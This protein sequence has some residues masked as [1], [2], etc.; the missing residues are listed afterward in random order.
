VVLCGVSGV[1]DTLMRN[2]LIEL[3]AWVVSANLVHRDIIVIEVKGDDGDGEFSRPI[4]V[5]TAVEKMSLEFNLT[6]KFNTNDVR[7]FCKEFRIKVG[8]RWVSVADP[9]PKVQSLCA[10]VH[11]GRGDLDLDERWVSFVA[12]LRHYDN[13]LVLDTLARATQQFYGLRKAPLGMCYAL[14]NIR[15]DRNL[16]YGFYG[17]PEQIS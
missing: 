1:F 11:L 7:Y 8:D 14:S 5:E 10:P 9:W 15:R 3:T 6:S 13:G 17:P 2:G 16:F 4:M 12:S